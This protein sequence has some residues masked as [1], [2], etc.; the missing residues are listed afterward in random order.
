M[1]EAFVARTS[2]TRVLLLLAIC[3][4]FVALS[5]WM[6]GAFG[7]PPKPGKEWVGWIGAPFFAVMGIMW[8]LRLRGPA[9]QI[10]ID[11]SG[12]TWR[13]WS[14]EHIPWSAV[15]RIDEYGIRGQTM[16]AVHLVDPKAHPPTRL[17]GKV[18][19]AQAGMGRGDFTMI[20][21]G[22]DRSA[23]DLREALRLRGP[24]QAAP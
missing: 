3:P 10:V 5:L 19:A 24:G 7:D 11:E 21:T 18:A 22:T 2:R 1:E 13:Q 6:A 20:A 9:D 17:M 15:L 23:D 16:F 14:D 12:L 4:V 8:A